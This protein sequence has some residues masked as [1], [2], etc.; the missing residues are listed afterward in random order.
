MAV[1][2]QRDLGVGRE[3]G[4][5]GGGQS[6]AQ[7]GGAQVVGLTC[8]LQGSIPHPTD[9]VKL[10]AEL[11]LIAAVVLVLVVIVEV[12]IALGCT[13]KR[14]DE[15]SGA[16]E[17]DHRLEDG[18]GKELGGDGGHGQQRGGVDTGT[19]SVTEVI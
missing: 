11:K 9:N 5:R 17:D 12:Q 14:R 3:G 10:E 16:G 1:N 19:D 2:A 7:D 15:G 6:G 13:G 8:R 18:L 4:G